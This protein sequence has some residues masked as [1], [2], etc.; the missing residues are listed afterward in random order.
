MLDNKYNKANSDF[1][2]ELVGL[3][4]NMYS[5]ALSLTA[6]PNNA[7][8]LMQETSLKVLTNREKYYTNSNFKGW[9]LTVM[10]N[11][12][13]NNYHRSIRTQNI[14]D[15]TADLAYIGSQTDT[16]GIGSPD[17][18]FSLQEINT[19]IEALDETYQLPFTLYLS[20]FKYKEI[21]E[22]LNLPLG[23]IKSRIFFARKQLQTELSDFK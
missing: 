4:P 15:D 5:F 11:L 8:D 23:T 1:E 2:Q 9:V 19:A 3:Q 12:F 14:I 10:R 20:G 22:K 6:D 21:A 16:E 18:E 17:H 13:I 7:E